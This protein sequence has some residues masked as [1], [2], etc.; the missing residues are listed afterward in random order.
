M[1]KRRIMVIKER[2]SGET[3]KLPENEWVLKRGEL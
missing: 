1:S 2:H 3:G